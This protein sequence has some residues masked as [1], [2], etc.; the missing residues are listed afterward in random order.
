LSSAREE[1][2]NNMDDENLSKYFK[3]RSCGIQFDNLGDMERHI[4]SEHPDVIARGQY[5]EIKSTENI[6]PF[7]DWWHNG[8]DIISRW[9]EIEKIRT[10][11]YPSTDLSAAK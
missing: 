8:Y 9:N 2:H 11:V 3:C 6:P 4:M 1:E 7:E 5:S 10:T